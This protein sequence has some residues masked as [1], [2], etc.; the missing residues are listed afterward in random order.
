MKFRRNRGTDDARPLVDITR[1]R[2]LAVKTK[3]PKLALQILRY[4]REHPEAQDT[5][6]GIMVWWVS[7]RAIKIWLPHVR[8]SLKTLVARGYLEKWTAD[9]RIFYRLG[10]SRPC[11]KIDSRKETGERGDEFFRSD[12]QIQ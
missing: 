10:E 2:C 7:D 1:H 6:E 11:R 4:L 12:S 9:G 5:L 3:L 8:R